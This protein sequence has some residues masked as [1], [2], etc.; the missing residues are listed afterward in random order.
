[1]QPYNGTFA[2]LW[3]LWWQATL[4]PKVESPWLGFRQTHDSFWITQLL[5]WGFT[6]RLFVLNGRDSKTNFARTARRQSMNLQ[7]SIE[8]YS[9][10]CGKLRVFALGHLWTALIPSSLTVDLSILRSNLCLRS[11]WEVFW[12]TASR[13]RDIRIPLMDVVLQELGQYWSST[14]WGDQDIDDAELFDVL[15]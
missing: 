8:G 14:S 11:T 4:H 1:M 9:R 10:D 12:L 2:S 6:A 5:C 7:M 13:I 3:C 15:L